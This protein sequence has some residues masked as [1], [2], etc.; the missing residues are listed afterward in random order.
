MS[1]RLITYFLVLRSYFRTELSEIM[2]ARDLHSNKC[3]AEPVWSVWGTGSREWEMRLSCTNNQ[4]CLLKDYDIIRT[5]RRASVDSSLN[6]LGALR[7]NLINSRLILI[8]PNWERKPAKGSVVRPSAEEAPSWPLRSALMGAPLEARPGRP[9]LLLLL[10]LKMKPNFWIGYDDG[11][12]AISHHINNLENACPIT[13]VLSIPMN[14]AATYIR[15][16]NEW[17]FFRWDIWAEL[18]G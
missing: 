18:L 7:G 2:T 3:D 6:F 14:T 13:C 4:L 11:L 15:S 12:T 16:Q 9:P 17:I 10:F 8:V 5:G 1:C